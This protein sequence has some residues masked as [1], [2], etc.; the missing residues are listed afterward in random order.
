V[1]TI[2]DALG[3]QR[4]GKK[5]IKG[6]GLA[7]IDDGQIARLVADKVYDYPENGPP[8]VIIKVTPLDRP[9]N[10]KQGEIFE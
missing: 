6:S 10:P 4:S 1:R 8:G 5:T 9:T 7:F 2:G 3:E